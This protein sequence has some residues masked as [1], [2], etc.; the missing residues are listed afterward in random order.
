MLNLI[1]NVI[2]A[3]CSVMLVCNLIRVYL[4][5]AQK[6]SQTDQIETIIL[7]AATNEPTAG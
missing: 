4:R 6:N 5:K 7:G 1:L 2:G 3:A